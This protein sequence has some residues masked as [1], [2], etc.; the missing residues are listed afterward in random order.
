METIDRI[1]NKNK[2]DQKHFPALSQHAVN[3]MRSAC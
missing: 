2:T 1:N 3:K